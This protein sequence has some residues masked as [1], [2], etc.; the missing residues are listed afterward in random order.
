MAPL[1]VRPLAL[2]AVLGLLLAGC[3]DKAPVDDGLRLPDG[4]TVPLDGS[5]TSATTGA[6]AGVVV[7]EAIR[8]VP[9]A[10]VSAI[11]VD[12]TATTDDSGVFHLGDLAPG[13]LAFTVGADGFLAIQASAEVVAGKVVQ[14]KVQL[15]RDTSPQ[16]YHQTYA[17][18]GLMQAWVGIGQFVAEIVIPGGSGLCNCRLTVQPEGNLTDAVVEAV[19][20][21]SFPDPA[22]LAEYYLSVEEVD[23]DGFL[24][25]QYCY[26]PC[27]MH[28]S[29]GDMDWRGG[30][31]EARLDGADAWPSYNQQ[32][33]LFVTLFYNGPAP[34]GWTLQ[35]DAP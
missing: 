35:D 29:A 10:L 5:G 7:D 24:E 14:S 15:V 19:W 32:I 28:L 11:G 1:A 20:E 22:G 3:S 9:G 33:K 25:T 31:I 17:L 2:L 27:R 26:S 30:P 12:A 6:I 16:P 34:Q 18:D 13:F 23:D 4:S 8:P 21:Q